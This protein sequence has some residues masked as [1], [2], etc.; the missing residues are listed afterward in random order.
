MKVNRIFLSVQGEG[1]RMGET[2]I[3]LRLQGCN[4]RCEW[5]DTKYALEGEYT[6]MTPQQVYDKIAKYACTT[7]CITGGE[8]LVQREELLELL[9]ILR[10]YNYFVH[11]FTNGTI[12]DFEIFKLVDF[13]SM[14]MKAPSSGMKSKLEFLYDLSRFQIPDT[15]PEFEIKVVVQTQEDLEFALFKVYP[16]CPTTLII[17]PCDSETPGVETLKALVAVLLHYNLKNVRILP[18]LHKLIWGRE[19]GR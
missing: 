19:R 4:L 10:Q 18:Q 15:P 7:L 14:D 17:Q 12:W 16:K 5:C 6:E 13:I 3:F 1:L 2:Q 8:P 9:K 11:L